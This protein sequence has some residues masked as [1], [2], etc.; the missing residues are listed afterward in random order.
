MWGVIFTG[1]YQIMEHQVEHPYTWP[2]FVFEFWHNMA[3]VHSLSLLILLWTNLAL[4]LAQHMETLTRELGVLYPEADD[5]AIAPPLMKNNWM[6]RLVEN[7][8][9]QGSFNYCVRQ[10][11][12]L[13]KHSI[14]PFS[15]CDVLFSAIPIM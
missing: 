2:Y 11:S 3:V 1:H 15:C 14:I 12:Y 5:D 9:G 8:V 4:N 6:F 13:S 7:E 10:L